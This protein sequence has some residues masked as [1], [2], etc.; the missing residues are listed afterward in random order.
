MSKINNYK[1]RL[2]AGIILTGALLF[3]SQNP[4]MAAN[5]VS[6]EMSGYFI[7]PGTLELEDYYSGE[8]I[9][10]AE[11]LDDPFNYMFTFNLSFDLEPHVSGY[12]PIFSPSA[13]FDDAVSNMS[14]SVDGN[15][16]WS[17]NGPSYVAQTTMLYDPAE[18]DHWSWS[19]SNGTFTTPDELT[20]IDQFGFELA[21]MTPDSV[22]ISL[23][24]ATRTLYDGQ[25]LS[26][27]LIFDGSEFTDMQLF[28]NWE[29]P[30]LY[31]TYGDPINEYYGFY[32]LIGT[33]TD[34]Q[35]S[36]VP[37]PAAV[38]LFGS[39]MLALGGVVGRK[40]RKVD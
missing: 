38:W 4:T 35:V 14:M 16:Y 15:P 11:L 8:I 10:D 23:D 34:V 6:Y 40:R 29:I 19:N 30:E 28:L 33:I 27:L 24:D 13:I 3:S 21:T 7:T 25:S 26:D 22:G 37:V 1:P 31:D 32:E 12:V 39:G 9:T 5:I 2:L 36:T 20:V 17:S 18:P